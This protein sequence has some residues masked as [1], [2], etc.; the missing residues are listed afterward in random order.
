MHDYP[1]FHVRLASNQDNNSRISKVH[2]NI[3]DSRYSQE[4]IQRTYEKVHN[5]LK[6]VPQN[7]NDSKAITLKL[8]KGSKNEDEKKQI[9]NCTPKKHMPYTRYLTFKSMKVNSLEPC[10]R[11][12]SKYEGNQEEVQRRVDFLNKTKWVGKQDFK[13]ASIKAAHR[14]QEQ[15]FIPN[16]VTRTP[17]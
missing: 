15:N 8:L 6:L 17:S 5:M 13:T 4:N 11:T 3:F 16:Y 12:S 2:S 9:I 1:M 10:I 7:L 14:A